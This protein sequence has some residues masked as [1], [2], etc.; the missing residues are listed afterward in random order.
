MYK[1]KTVKEKKQEGG[2]TISALGTG[3][4]AKIKGVSDLRQ[5]GFLS[6]PWIHSKDQGFVGQ[7]AVGVSWP[8]IA[9]VHCVMD[10]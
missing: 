5:V 9:A 10:T 6:R 1:K 4:I 8:L 3:F 7:E 2:I